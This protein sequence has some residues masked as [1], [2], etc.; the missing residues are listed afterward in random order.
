MQTGIWVIA[1]FAIMIAV[2]FAAWCV[3]FYS[4]LGIL[5]NVRDGRWFRLLFQFGWWDPRRADQYIEPPGMLHH[6]RLLKAMIWF[7]AA[8]FCALIYGIWQA[9]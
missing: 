4:M 8:V 9:G 3:A 7:F 6:G 2:A 5:T 1:P